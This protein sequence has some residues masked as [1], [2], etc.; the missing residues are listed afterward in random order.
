M[1]KREKGIVD[2]TDEQVYYKA[3]HP[4]SRAYGEVEKE[5]DGVPIIG[6]YEA[7][8][9]EVVASM[10][11]GNHAKF[12]AACEKHSVGRERTIPG[13]NPKRKR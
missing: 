12:L 2:L 4:R 8:H 11:E 1:I 3:T 13:Y 10:F 6:L 5:L 9:P 7:N